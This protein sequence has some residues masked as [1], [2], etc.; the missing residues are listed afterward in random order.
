[1]NKYILWFL[2]DEIRYKYKVFLSYNGAILFKKVMEYK[3]KD[4]YPD[5][6]NL[7]DFYILKKSDPVYEIWWKYSDN[8]EDL[9]DC[10]E[11]YTKSD[12]CDAIIEE[13]KCWKTIKEVDPEFEDIEVICKQIVYKGELMTGDNF[14]FLNIIEKY[15]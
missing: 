9:S 4:I 11:F 14:S 15:Y 8:T 10:G 13:E 1:M 6:Y 7:L 12:L 5:T 3:L 2:F